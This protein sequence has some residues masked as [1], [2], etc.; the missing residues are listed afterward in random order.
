M[1]APELFQVKRLSVAV[2]ATSTLP[3]TRSSSWADDDGTNVLEMRRSQAANIPRW[4]ATTETA[5]AMKTDSSRDLIPTPPNA[6]GRPRRKWAWAIVT[7]V[8][9][10]YSR[11]NRYETSST[12]G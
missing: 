9:W 5:G 11:R 2:T 12:G 1:S 3:S 8:A 6:D 4:S 10:R 7:C